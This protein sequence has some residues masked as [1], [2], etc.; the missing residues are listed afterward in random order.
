[1]ILPLSG[2]VQREAFTAGATDPLGIPSDGYSAA[3]DVDVNGWYPPSAETVKA[4]TGRRAIESD[5]VLIVPNGTV[6]KDK[7]RWTI[8]GF[9][10]YLQQG[11]ADDF[12]H[13]PFGMEVPLV[14]YL[15]AVKG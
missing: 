10:A 2:T 13:G 4:N 6:C 9:G 14:V 12:N 8:P 5:L 11:A 1:M 15:K 7:D 3:V